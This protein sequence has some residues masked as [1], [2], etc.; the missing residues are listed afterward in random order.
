MPGKAANCLCQRLLEMFPIGSDVSGSFKLS[1]ADGSHPLWGY[2][3]PYQSWLAG[4]SV[5]LQQLQ[6]G[7][8]QLWQESLKLLV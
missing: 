8:S 1:S 7:Q 4:R 2:V 3:G 6:A 5:A